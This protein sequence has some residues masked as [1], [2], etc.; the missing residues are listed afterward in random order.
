MNTHHI[1]TH[2][3]WIQRR[4]ELLAKEKE[5]LRARDALS[6]A[7]RELPWERVEK[8]YV[9]EG[10]DGSRTLADLF[11]KHSQ[12]AIYHFMFAPDWEAGCKSCTFWAD[13]FDHAAPHLAARD[14]AFYAVSR[15]PYAK[16]AA[17]RKRMG[18]SFPWVSSAGSEFNFDYDVSFDD[19]KQGQIY[20]YAPRTMKGPELPGFSVFTRDGDSIFHTYSTYARGIDALNVTYQILDLVPKGRDEDQFKFAMEWLRRRD[21]YDART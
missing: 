2:T 4:K 16:L 15:A 5:F 3:D 7:R 9:F 6:S 10:P 21:E 14:V 11:G 12:L 8:R 17:Y 1:V 13:S 19:S 20:N 18:W